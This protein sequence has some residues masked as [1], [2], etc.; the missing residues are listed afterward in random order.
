MTQ[1]RIVE[2]RISIHRDLLR[3]GIRSLHT[4]DEP[5]DQ[6]AGLLI[7]AWPDLD[8]QNVFRK[9]GQNSVHF[10]IQIQEEQEGLCLVCYPGMIRTVSLQS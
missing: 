8:V 6:Y 9:A 10:Q 5:L 1:I 2:E 7:K 4:L 3:L